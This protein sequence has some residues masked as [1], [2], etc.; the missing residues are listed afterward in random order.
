MILLCFFLESE[1]NFEILKAQKEM[2]T[3]FKR[4]KTAKHD[5]K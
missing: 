1:S 4:Q 5:H 3:F 2:Q